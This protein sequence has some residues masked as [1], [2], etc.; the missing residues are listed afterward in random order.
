[1][2]F[3]LL[4]TLQIPEAAQLFCPFDYYLPFYLA[5][6]GFIDTED[7]PHMDEI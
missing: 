1:M 6:F 2:P 4:N 3:C 5:L 7:L